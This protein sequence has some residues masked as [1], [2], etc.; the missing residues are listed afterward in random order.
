MTALATGEKAPM[1]RAA[2][3]DPRLRVVAAVAF[4]LVVVSLDTLPLLAASFV[5]ALLAGAL[6][7]LP[8][9]PTLRKMAGM[10]A[11]M[12]PVL[13]FLPFTLPGTPLAELGPL[14]ASAEGLHRAF[15]I[16]LTANAVTLT[17]FAL[18]G[19][20]EPAALGHALAGLGLP[21]RLVHL[22]LLTVRYIALLHEEHA[23]LRLAMRARAFR[24]KAD[25]HT[26]RSLGW[27]YGML[28]VR[29]A[30]RA[31]RVLQAMKCRG[32]AGRY[33]LLEEPR[34]GP[35]DLLFA[36]ATGGA[37]LALLL[38]ARLP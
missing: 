4:A 23:R 36:A 2:S 30:E 14:T 21:E 34:L 17:L 19:T 26:W 31:E 28:L 15:E 11:F 13:L 3:L 22:M 7:R 5:L 18:V 10:D 20:L 29:S 33:H 1:V 37:L 35:R 25:R 8:V 9:G 16:V 6:A 12:A 38:A 27:L 32:F 24:A